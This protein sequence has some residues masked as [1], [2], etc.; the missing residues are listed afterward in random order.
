MKLRLGD[1]V[2]ETNNIAYAQITGYGNMKIHFVGVSE[3]LTVHCG[4][5]A[6]SRSRFLGNANELLTK[7]EDLDKSIESHMHAVETGSR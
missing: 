6:N 5:Q 2:I 7:I 1:T 4:E 3:P